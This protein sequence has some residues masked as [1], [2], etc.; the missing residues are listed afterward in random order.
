M[1][2]WMNIPNLAS[3]HQAIR[4]LR[5]IGVAPFDAHAG[6]ADGRTTGNAERTANAV[7]RATRISSCRRLYNLRIAMELDFGSLNRTEPVC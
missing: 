2:Q 3:R 7:I 6:L 1:P 4:A 5:S